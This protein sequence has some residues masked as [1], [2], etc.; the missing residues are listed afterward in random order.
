MTRHLT[1][2]QTPIVEFSSILFNLPFH[3]ISPLS[4]THF[5]D[6]EKAQEVA[7]AIAE[8]GQANLGV[9]LVEHS[10]RSPCFRIKISDT[11]KN[12]LSLGYCI[13]R[14]CGG[15]PDL[16]GILTGEKVSIRVLETWEH[17]H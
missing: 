15:H 9:H 10:E 1:S 6:T 7:N 16:Q 2:T 5:K 8:F 14:S 17:H 13:T 4:S 3:I 11:G 12:K